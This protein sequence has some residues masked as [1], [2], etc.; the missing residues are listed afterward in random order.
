M[1]KPLKA[2]PLILSIFKTPTLQYSSTPKPLDIF[3]GKAVA[4]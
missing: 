2:E 1:Q 4:I 3:T